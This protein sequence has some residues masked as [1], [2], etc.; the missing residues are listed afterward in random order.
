MRLLFLHPFSL[1]LTCLLSLP[2]C[3]FA[4]P[5]NCFLEA[6]DFGCGDKGN[7]MKHSF[8]A[9]QGEST[10]LLLRPR[11]EQV[12][13]AHP[14]GQWGRG[15]TSWATRQTRQM[16]SHSHEKKNISGHTTEMLQN[17]CKTP[18]WVCKFLWFS[19][20]QSVRS[21]RVEP[22][23][24]LR[25]DNLLHKPSV[26]CC[27]ST[28]AECMDYWCQQRASKTWHMARTHQS[29]ML[30]DPPSSFIRR[31][32]YFRF[33]CRLL[34]RFSGNF[35]F[36]AHKP[37]PQSFDFTQHASQLTCVY[38]WVCSEMPAW[39]SI[40]MGCPLCPCLL[41]VRFHSRGKG[42][43]GGVCCRMAATPECNW[44]RWGES[45]VW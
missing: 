12:G 11:K 9:K 39:I 23:L 33:C 15:G 7:G 14:S 26:L 36:L 40:L 29:H 30:H 45:A 35:L 4:L 3:L 1:S 24:T 10:E 38:F 2:P 18:A 21:W 31:V 8:S 25:T 17:G 20:L 6:G 32:E 42:R 16:Y 28:R 13:P 44:N 27:L 5:L 19:P 37:P 22:N 41:S 34:Q 43:D